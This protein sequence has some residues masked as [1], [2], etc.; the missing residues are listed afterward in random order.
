MVVLSFIPFAHFF[1]QNYS[2]QVFIGMSRYLRGS[3]Y[4]Y[5]ITENDFLTLVEEDENPDAFI[6]DAE[7]KAQDKISLFLR[8]KY[9][10]VSLF[11]TYPEYV[12]GVTYAPTGTTSIVWYNDFLYQPIVNTNS[13]P[14]TASWQGVEPRFPL[15][16]EW[17][18]V[19][20]LCTYIIEYP[21]TIFLLTGNL[22]MKRS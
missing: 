8:D 11:K 5:K 22:L 7:L 1:N 14:S 17:M 12:T 15:I 20:S 2:F 19:I 4:R 21:R 16:V 10:L 6:F 13:L 9:D 3:D 18:V